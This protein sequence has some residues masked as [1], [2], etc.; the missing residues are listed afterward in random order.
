M[1]VAPFFTVI[2]IASLNVAVA[3][4]EIAAK[5]LGCH[6][7]EDSMSLAGEGVDYIIEGMNMIRSGEIRHPESLEGLSDE[8]LKA[9]AAV[10]DGG[11]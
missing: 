8:D 5:C 6:D 1:R 3:G 10:L 7:P 2:V 9:I 4:D 11:G